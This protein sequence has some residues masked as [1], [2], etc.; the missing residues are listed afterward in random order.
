[1]GDLERAAAAR[2]QGFDGRRARPGE[3]AGDPVARPAEAKIAA[4][5]R[6]KRDGDRN[7]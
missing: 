2:P 6:G 3:P 7:R 1:M 4:A 5:A